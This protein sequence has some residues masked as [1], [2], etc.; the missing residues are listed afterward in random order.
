MNSFET[1]EPPR[2]LD[3]PSRVRSALPAKRPMMGLTNREAQAQIAATALIFQAIA[4]S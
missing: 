3:D 4:A 1:M 2:G